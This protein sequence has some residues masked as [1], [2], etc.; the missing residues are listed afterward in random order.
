MGSDFGSADSLECGCFDGAGAH[1]YDF[2]RIYRLTYFSP[3]K[4]AGF[5]SSGLILPGVYKFIAL[6]KV[7][8]WATFSMPRR[9][10]LEKLVGSQNFAMASAI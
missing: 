6:F 9:A 3:C 7:A 5:K 10:E 4:L 1:F 8:L 2:A